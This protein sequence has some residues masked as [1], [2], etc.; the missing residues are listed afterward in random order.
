VVGAGVDLYCAAFVARHRGDRAALVEPGLCGVV[1]EQGGT[2]RLVVTDDRAYG[3]LASDI[4]AAQAGVAYVFEAAPR[5]DGFMRS[6]PGWRPERPVTA[7][8]CRDIAAGSPARLPDG[9]V[10]RPVSRLAGDAPA[11]VA[12]EAAAAVAVASDPGI[13]EPV[14]DFARFLRALP[15][16]VQLFAAVD[17][18]GVAWATSGCD[19]VGEDARVFFVNT[20]PGRRGR[21]IGGAMTQAALRAAALAGARRGVLDATDAG[22]SVYLRLGFEVAGR[23]T[24][25]VRP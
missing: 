24:R 12:L 8:V 17:E 23:V 11:G 9:L 7:M 22:L 13:T 25:Y 21:G 6:R 5:C 18:A 19:V 10:L 16:S 15:P 20:E 3:R 14:A 4:P 2:V 1:S